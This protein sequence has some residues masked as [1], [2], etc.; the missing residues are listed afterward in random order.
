MFGGSVKRISDD[1]IISHAKETERKYFLD[2]FLFVILYSLANYYQKYD[3]KSVLMLQFAT[4][5]I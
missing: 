4:I 1:F 5:D 2:Y 3:R